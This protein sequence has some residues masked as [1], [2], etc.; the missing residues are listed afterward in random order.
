MKVP[1][2]FE[3]FQATLNS[4]GFSAAKQSECVFFTRVEGKGKVELN[5]KGTFIV[6]SQSSLHHDIVT[7]CNDAGWETVSFAK[8]WTNLKIK[9]LDSLDEIG[10]LDQFLQ[11]ITHLQGMK[12]ARK[13]T[14]KKSA[15]VVQ[16]KPA[17]T[18]EV[19]AK[20]LQLIKMVARRNK[21]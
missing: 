17:G 15:E 13:S 20:N 18:D 21:K 11:L 6:G 8:A 10:V 19:K 1:V 12:V 16:L 2:S 9:R 3:A 5:T 7:H 14:P 4:K